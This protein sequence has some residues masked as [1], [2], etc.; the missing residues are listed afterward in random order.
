VTA[1]RA[2]LASLNR[3]TSP[4][5]GVPSSLATRLETGANDASALRAAYEE[6]LAM[7]LVPKAELALVDAW[8]DALDEIGAAR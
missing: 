3:L 2:L 5:E 6:L 8:N 1:R 7:G 4:A